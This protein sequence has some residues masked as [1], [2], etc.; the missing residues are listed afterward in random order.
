ME[1]QT[2]GW[3]IGCDDFSTVSNCTD[4]D[5]SSGCFCT[6]GVL[7]DDDVCILP[8]ACASKQ[9]LTY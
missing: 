4:S 8:D 7:L 2:C 5:C 1:Y 9:S 6:D 3:E